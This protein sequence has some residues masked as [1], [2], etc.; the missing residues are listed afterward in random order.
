MPY[1]SSYF[2]SDRRRLVVERGWIWQPATYMFL[3]AGALHILFNMLGIWMF[4]VELERMWGTRFFVQYYAVTGLGG[5]P[6]VLLLALLPFAARR[7]TYGT[8]TDRRVGRALRP[9]ARFAIYYPDRPILMLLVFRS[10]RA[11]SS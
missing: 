1:C 6:H 7:P 10:R 8:R 5:G 2:G 4:G 3:H 11:T 9:A